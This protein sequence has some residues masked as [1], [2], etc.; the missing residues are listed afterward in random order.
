MTAIAGSSVAALAAVVLTSSASAAQDTSG[1]SATGALLVGAA[2]ADRDGSVTPQE[3]MTFVA[4]VRVGSD[5]RV[6]RFDLAA[7]LFTPFFDANDDRVIETTELDAV[8]VRWDKDGSDAVDDADL[9]IDA[10]L[11]DG[12]NAFVEQL[13]LRL[14]D[15]QLGDAT[16]AP[17][18]GRVSASEWRRFVAAQPSAN[19]RLLPVA[20]YAWTKSALELPPPTDRDAFT[21]DVY[22]LTV[23]AELDLDKDGGIGVADLMSLHGRMDVDGDG[24]IAALELAP[25]PLVAQ[26]DS[27]AANQKAELGIRD[28]L[29]AGRRG[30]ARAAAARAVPAF[31]RRCAGARRAHAEAAAR[32]REHGRRDGERGAGLV[33][34]PRAG[35]RGPHARLR[36]CARVAGRSQ[37]NRLRRPRAAARGPAFRP[38]ARSR[39]DRCGAGTV[40]A[41]L[42]RHARGASA[43]RCVGERRDP[44]RRVPR[45]RLAARR[46]RTR[47][48][49]G[50]TGRAAAAG[51]GDEHRGAASRVPRRS[52]ATTSSGASSS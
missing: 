46:R 3:W 32:V 5:E 38:R 1:W 17:H 42:P 21:P 27:G 25:P 35:V 36:V 15:T 14:A 34:V 33:P 23:F 26:G 45:G 24:T 11:F 12:E 13:V 31:A 29:S 39:G 18:D 47:G 28:H 4:G 49:R 41:L 20:V 19:G 16:D 22:L 37:R 7:Q 44:V 8:F 9:A 51:A 43:R 6:D 10:T 52:T 40:R 30:A 50:A 2:D 48:T